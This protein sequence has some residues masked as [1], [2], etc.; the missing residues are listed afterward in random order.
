MQ[1]K[2]LNPEQAKELFKNWGETA[3]VC[4]ASDTSAPEEIG[5][6]CLNS[7]HYSGSRGDYIKFLITDVPRFTVDQAVRHE[8]G[9]F[10]NVQSFRYVNKD[11]FFYEVP[12]EITD[13]Q[14]MLDKYSAFMNSSSALYEAIQQYVYEKTNSHERA[15]EQARY[16]LPMATH[17]AFVIGFTIEALIHFMNMRLCVRAEDTIHH[18]AVLMRNATVEVLPKLKNKLVPNCQALL[19]CP[20][21][22]KSCHAYPTKKELKDMI[23]DY[24]ALK[25][26]NEENKLG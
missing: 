13:S 24:K 25:K 16:V 4:Y 8:V 18:L 5:K 20:E 12:V 17:T 11:T 21:G 6:H 9:V 2:L 22:A 14:E 7:G 26:N 3:A 19:W 23:K 10:K 15:N 1:V